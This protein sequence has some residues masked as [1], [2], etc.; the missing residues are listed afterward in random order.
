MCGGLLCAAIEALPAAIP[1]LKPDF[2]PG[3]K[4]RVFVTNGSAIVEFVDLQERNDGFFS[5][6]DFGKRTD[7]KP[8]TVY[9]AENSA[10]SCSPYQSLFAQIERIRLTA[11]E[12]E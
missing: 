11:R 3:P 1:P 12:A 7:F 6:D 9:L 10:V 2:F 4:N 8:A 5:R